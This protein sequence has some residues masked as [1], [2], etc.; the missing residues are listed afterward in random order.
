MEI[1]DV[2]FKEQR[3]ILKQDWEDIKKRREQLT[4]DVTEFVKSITKL[5]AKVGIDFKTPEKC[6]HLVILDQKAEGS[7]CA[8]CDKFLGMA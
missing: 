6:D 4:K 8:V 7:V 3:E 5:Y 1:T 2:A